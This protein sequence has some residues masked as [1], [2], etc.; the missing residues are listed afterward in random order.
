MYQ[1][2]ITRKTKKVDG[3]QIQMTSHDKLKIFE[4]YDYEKSTEEYNTHTKS[5]LDFISIID[6]STIHTILELFH[7]DT[8]KHTHRLIKIIS[9]QNF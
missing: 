8:D 9:L 6:Y 7:Y 5:E 1:I 2:F 4:S 3:N